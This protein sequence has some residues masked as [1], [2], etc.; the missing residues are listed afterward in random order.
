MEDQVYYH[1]MMSDLERRKRIQ[2]H[3][4][5]PEISPPTQLLAYGSGVVEWFHYFH[6]QKSL[7][8]H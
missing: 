5:T 7:E 6:N 8:R 1:M 3:H 4:Q 2:N